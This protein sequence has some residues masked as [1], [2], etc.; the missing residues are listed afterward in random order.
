MWAWGEHFSFPQKYTWKWKFEMLAGLYEKETTRLFKAIVGPGMTVVD[1]GAHIGYFTRLAA[2]RVGEGGRV[3]AFEPDEENRK[4]LLQNTRRFPNVTICANA[5]TDHVGTVSFFHIPQSTGCHSTI[6]PASTSTR[7]TV[8]ATTLDAF[9]AE[10]G[11][12]HIDVIKMDIEGGEYVALLG[13]EKTL[14]TKGLQIIM[15]YNLEALD[16]SHTDN[17]K[18]LTHFA[19]RGFTIDAITAQ[20]L[21]RIQSPYSDSLRKY[22]GR[23]NTINIFCKRV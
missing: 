21:R 12:S 22:L 10:H 15:E 14:S 11:I 23:E 4:R 13:M 3:Y 17:E 5:V 19:N 6:A 18:I 1:I 2:R 16:N 8:P 9:T 7:T 20:G